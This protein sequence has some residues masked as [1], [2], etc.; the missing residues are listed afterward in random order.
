MY[1][2]DQGGPIGGMT[3]LGWWPQSLFNSLSDRANVIQWLGEVNYQYN[4]T[5]PS[6]GS[7]HF[8]SKHEGEAASF[9]DCFGFDYDGTIYRRFYKPIPFVDRPECYT[10]SPWYDTGKPE[11]QHFF[12]GGP[13]GCSK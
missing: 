11:Y 12:Y 7:G 1:R 13:G 5:G 10:I 8:P 6:M 4:E 2:E 9:N 3:L